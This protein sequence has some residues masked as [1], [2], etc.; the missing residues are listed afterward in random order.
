MKM[1]S[2]RRVFDCR[3]R[4]Q[5][6]HTYLDY[7]GGKY[8]KKYGHYCINSFDA[9]MNHKAFHKLGVL[10]NMKNFEGSN[11]VYHLEKSFYRQT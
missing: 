4:K 3:S 6:L 9:F 8:F 2:S 11:D 5:L 10:E 7:N 1:E